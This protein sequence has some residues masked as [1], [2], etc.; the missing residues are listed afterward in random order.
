MV[1]NVFS[2]PSGPLMKWLTDHSNGWLRAESYHAFHWHSG[3]DLCRRIS[4]VSPL[5]LR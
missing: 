2:S 3:R 4:R 5:D 1:E